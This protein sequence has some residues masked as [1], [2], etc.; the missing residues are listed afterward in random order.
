MY[1]KMPKIHDMDVFDIK[2]SMISD[3]LANVLYADGSI[4]R[5]VPFH[6]YEKLCTRLAS[7]RNTMDHFNKNI[8]PLVKGNMSYSILTEEKYPDIFKH[9]DF[10]IVIC[11]NPNLPDTDFNYLQHSVH[12]IM[13]QVVSQ[14][15]RTLDHMFFGK[16]L[17]I[18]NSFMCDED[19]EGFKKSYETMIDEVNK[20]KELNGKF[21]SPFVENHEQ[22]N[23]CSKFSF[24][25]TDTV[26]ED[27]VVMCEIPHF[28]QCDRIPLKKTPLYVSYNDSIDFNRAKEDGESIVGSFDLY[29]IKINHMFISFSSN[30]EEN[31]KKVSADFIDISIPKK[32]D[33]ELINFFKNNKALVMCEKI[34]NVWVYVP[35]LLYSIKEIERMINL[36]KSQEDKVAKR[37]VKRKALIKH[38]KDTVDEIDVE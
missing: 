6:F 33:A 22:R 13:N 4:Y 23:F 34:T 5:A 37:I 2:K 30:D 19:I 20:K 11:I 10:D 17:E 25:I 16:R 35:D 24:I 29:R 15:K 12:I 31:M 8:I 1:K 36:Y 32:T 26:K 3:V 14:Y 28:A 27:K 21:I 9:S 18:D 38:L 7:D